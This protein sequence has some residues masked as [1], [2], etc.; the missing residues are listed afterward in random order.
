M[1]TL[2][3]T[4][5][6]VWLLAPDSILSAIWNFSVWRAPHAHSACHKCHIKPIAWKTMTQTPGL[7]NLENGD[8]VLYFTLLY[9]LRYPLWIESLY[10]KHQYF[11]FFIC[12]ICYLGWEVFITFENGNIFHFL[13]FKWEQK[14]LFLRS[15]ICN[16]AAM[17]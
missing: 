7:P 4:L 16:H 3:L 17:Q 13:I 12:R 15:Q 6:C 5:L 2:F 10:I 9:T 11:F 8:G 1:L 14:P